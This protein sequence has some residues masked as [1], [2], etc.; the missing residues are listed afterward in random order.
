MIVRLKS[1]VL[2]ELNWE[3][4]INENEIYKFIKDDKFGKSKIISKDEN[5]KEI[6]NIIKRIP[7]K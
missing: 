3:N 6:I 5:I 7:Y 1:G 4:F 2:K